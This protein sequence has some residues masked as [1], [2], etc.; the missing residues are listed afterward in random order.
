MPTTDTQAKAKHIRRLLTPDDELTLQHAAVDA[1][2]DLSEYI[3]RTLHE[4]AEQIRTAQPTGPATGYKFEFVVTDFDQ[5]QADEFMTEIITAIET[6]GGH[7]GGGFHP[8]DD[9]GNP[10]N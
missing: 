7:I 2:T 10:V 5:A 3:R 4:K 1:H 8:V 6:E 9:N